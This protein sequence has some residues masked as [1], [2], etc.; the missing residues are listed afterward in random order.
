MSGK[1]SKTNQKPFLKKDRSPLMLQDYLRDDTISSCS[2]NGFKSFPRRQCCP[3]TTVRLLLQI[4]LNSKPKP[5]LFHKASKAV[6]KAVRSL[7]F[8]SSSSRKKPLHLSKSLSRR[9]LRKS[10]FWRRRDTIVN[11][12]RESGRWRS[13]YEFL[14][15]Q[16]HT[17]PLLREKPIAASSGSGA[18]VERVST[19]SSS[20]QSKNNGRNSCCESEFTA[21]SGVNDDGGK[22]Y[23]ASGKGVSEREGV[24]SGGES[25]TIP[26]AAETAKTWRP[27][28]ETEQFS[29]VS[30]LDCP[31][32]DDDEEED[33]GKKLSSSFH[34]TH[35]HVDGTK[36]KLMRKLRRFERLAELKPLDLE[37]RINTIIKQDVEQQCSIVSQ[38]TGPH[39][40]LSIVKERAAISS[41]NIGL[42]SKCELLLLD[43]FE[44]KLEISR[45]QQPEE[46]ETVVEE[47][48]NGEAKEMLGGWEVKECRN[49]YLKHMDDEIGEWRNVG[50]RMEKVG[51]ELENCIF[52]SL[53]NE[54]LELYINC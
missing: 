29:P 31:F 17:P 10:F 46:L 8:N 9:L 37:K 51:L 23:I 16:D 34:Q 21:D 52:T 1:N 42:I 30:I 18:T 27:N 6:V 32:K 48:L 53:I 5:P 33:D 24:R 11:V 45:E 49:V 14:E 36:R 50:G 22:N 2:S 38:S 19:S 26:Y 40:L 28:E 43:F 7:P 44:E 41:S 47:W 12:G 35:V 39:E 25:S 20:S 3:T 4:D 54:V 13:F 15:E